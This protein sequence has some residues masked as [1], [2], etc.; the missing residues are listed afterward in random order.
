LSNLKSYLTSPPKHKK[1]L[2]GVGVFEREIRRFFK[3]PA[4]TILGPLGSSILYFAIF[5]YSIGKLANAAGTEGQSISN[6]IDYLL[7]LIPGIMTMESIN[8]S[9]QNPM[10]SIMISKWTGTIVDMLMAPLEPIA[11]W[12]AYILG[13]MVRASLVATMAYLAGSVFANQF[14]LHN[15]LALVASIFLTA[16]IFGSLG[17]I[18]GILCKDWDQIGLILSF[19]LQPLVF[20]SGVFFAFSGLPESISWAPYAN[21]I[22]YLVNLFRYSVTGVSEVSPLL[23]FLVA[24]T[25][26]LFAAS[27]SIYVI[28]SGKGMRA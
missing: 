15:V 26:M 19:V 9:I 5:K 27:G 18:A 20:L 1:Y 24:L 14:H 21:P 23:C 3:V 28:K 16:G 25:F 4:Q 8:A 2:P 13:A 7:F 17:I 11:M 10:S 12:M 22:F 6:G